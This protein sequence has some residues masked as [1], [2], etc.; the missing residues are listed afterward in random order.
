MKRQFL[1]RLISILF[2]SLFFTSCLEEIEVEA[3]DA[4]EQLVVEGSINNSSPVHRITLFSTLQTDNIPTN[5]RIGEGAIVEINELGGAT[6][7]LPEIAPGV[8]QTIPNQLVAEI[9][10]S[11]QLTITL[12]NGDTYQSEVET[13]PEPL[14][15]E[16][17]EARFKE[18]FIEQDDGT[19]D[20][21]VG[22]DLI[23]ELENSTE[24]QF[25]I[26]KN[27][28]FAQVEI[29]YGDCFFGSPAGPSIC[30]AFRDPI[31]SNEVVV[32]SNQ[33]IAGDSYLF[34]SINVPVDAKMEYIAILEVNSMSSKSFSF[35]KTVNDQ[36]SRPGSIF[37]RPIAPV[38]G[39][40]RHV[41]GGKTALGYFQ[42]Y[43]TTQETICFTRENVNVSISVPGP[44]PCPTLC[45]EV[46]SPAFF[47]D[48]Q[49]IFCEM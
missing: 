28:G 31:V 34:N 21:I 10:K 32:G 46:W 26:V 42:A 6:Y 40:I 45:T 13:I 23:V 8:Y 30:W 44:I 19:T 18:E 4:Q 7:S 3:R 47:G 22:H 27:R 1:T 43:A 25:F 35:W 17:S 48:L 15:V 29:G 41:N 33:N 38:V 37:D 39:N 36:L 24:D 11:Y 20:R 12:S 16:S 49:S 9:G 2:L 5:S 14:V